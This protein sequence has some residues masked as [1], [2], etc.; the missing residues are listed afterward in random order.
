MIIRKLRQAGTAKF[1]VS[2]ATIAATLITRTKL[3]SWT[4]VS[5]PMPDQLRRSGSMMVS[6]SKLSGPTQRPVRCPTRRGW[7]ASY[8]NQSN[9][10]DG[11]RAARFDVDVGKADRIDKEGVYAATIKIIEVQ[12]VT[13]QDGPRSLL[14]A[15][16]STWTAKI[17]KESQVCGFRDCAGHR[18]SV[19]VA[20][21]ACPIEGKGKRNGLRV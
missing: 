11:R 6:A 7:L 2:R 4:R 10:D 3:R 21:P 1:F 19:G 5:V 9:R 13:F 15:S 20:G 14:D 16:G 8:R 17:E 18:D 12:E